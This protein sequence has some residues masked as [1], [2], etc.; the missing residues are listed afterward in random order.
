MMNLNSLVEADRVH[1]TVY[2]DPEI[3]NAEMEKIWERTWVY[4]GHVS[5]VPN[6]GDYCAVTIGRPSLSAR[7]TSRSLGT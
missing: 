3:F 2:T 5:Q 1:K 7:G 4:C 6:P